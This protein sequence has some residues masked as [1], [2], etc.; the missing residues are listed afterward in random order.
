MRFTVPLAVVYIFIN[1]TE[2]I[3]QMAPLAVR[4]YFLSFLGM[5][6]NIFFINYFQAILQPSKAL[7][8]CAL[9]GLVLCVTLAYLLPLVLM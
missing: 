8:V 9:R 4:L 5:S 2:Q 3:L 7:T 6:L 1:P